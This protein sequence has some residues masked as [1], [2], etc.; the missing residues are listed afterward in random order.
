[1]FTNRL[2]YLFIGIALLVVTACAPQVELPPATSIPTSTAP[3]VPTPTLLPTSTP[4]PLS[5]V[6]VGDS[7]P[8]NSSQDCP[9]C[10]S[11][12]DRYAEAF[13][14]ATGQAVKVQNLSQHNGLQIDGLL[15]VI[16]HRR[17][18]KQLHKSSSISA[19]L[20]WHHKVP[21]P[22]RTAKDKSLKDKSPRSFCYFTACRIFFMNQPQSLFR[23]HSF[24]VSVVCAQ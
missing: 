14:A 15:Q 22:S 13:A 8:Y 3:P 1:M 20:P 5:L 11:F 6:V 10:T 7:I 18:M 9:G 12:V 4:K 21:E 24:A 17:A 16:H 19:L 2:F 23:S